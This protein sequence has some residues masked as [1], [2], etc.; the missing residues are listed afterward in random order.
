MIEVIHYQRRPTTGMESVERLFEDVRN[1]LPKDIAAKVVISRYTSNGFFPRLYNVLEAFVRQKNLNHITGDVHYLSVFLKHRKTILTILDCVMMER[2]HGFRRWV[3]WVLWLWLPE[4]RSCVITTISE[5]TRQQILT[6]LKCDPSK[7]RV[8]YCG[9]SPEFNYIP[10]DFNE[11][12][13]RLLQI[14]TS[15]N[16]N[17]GRIISAVIGMRCE[18][19]IVGVL[20][21]DHKKVLT[22]G[23]V[24][25]KNFSNISRMELLSL[26]KY[27]DVVLFAST[28]EGFGLPIIEANAVG[29]PVLTSNTWS[30]PEVAGNAACLVDPCKVDEIRAGILK[31]TADTKY[32]TALIANGLENIKRFSLQNIVQQYADIYREVSAG[33]ELAN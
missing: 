26:Y 7:V 16:K 20:S 17:I 19:I 32:R 1:N 15:E 31:I 13:P 22:A 27:C 29:R 11:E 25:Y 12:C 4:K 23:N 8:I 9:L 33:A 6:Y 2:L 30:M 5:S 18:L 21:S 14:G 24:S 3:Y 10:K 28:Y